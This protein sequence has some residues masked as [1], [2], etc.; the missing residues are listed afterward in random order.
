MCYVIYISLLVL[1]LVYSESMV[2]E[3]ALS[4]VSGD[5]QMLTVALG[6]EIV[7]VLWPL[8]LL[9]MVLGSAVTFFVSRKMYNRESR[10]RRKDT[11]SRITS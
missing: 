7:A 6:W 5:N 3:Y 9:A 8:S 4:V 2:N 1:A 11:N 10:T